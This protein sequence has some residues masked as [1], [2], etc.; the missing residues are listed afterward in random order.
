[1]SLI[2]SKKVSQSN[3]FVESPYAVELTTHE[4]K[5]I[6]YSI[7]HCREED[8]ALIGKKQGK[9]YSFTASNLAKILN[10]SLSRIVADGDKLA[11][12]ITQ[13]RIIH[14]VI[15]E[16]NE[17]EE[18]LYLPIIISAR[19][20]HGIFEFELNYKILPFFINI[21][22]PFTEYQLNHLLSMR[23]AYAIKLYKLLYQYK[24]IGHRKF[25]LYDLKAQFGIKDKYPQYKDLRK[26]VVE[27]AV[28]Q[29]NDLTDLT[30]EFN[31]VKFGKKVEKLEFTFNLKRQMLTNKLSHSS[32]NESPTID[33][34]LDSNVV[35]LN[36]MQDLIS[37]I[38]S[39]ISSI[40]KQLIA[41]YFKDKGISYVQASIEYAK[42]NS[43]TNFDKYLSDTLNNGWAEVEVKKITNKK[44][45][46]SAK[47]LAIKQEQDKKQQEKEQ[48]NLNR[49]L[50][51]HEWNKLLDADKVHYVDYAKFIISKHNKKLSSFTTIEQSLPL[52]IYAVSNQKFYDRVLEGYVK[53]ILNL[54]LNINDLL[55]PN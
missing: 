33:G 3:E 10:T 12:S 24:N 16:K 14:K 49:S 51:E 42:K 23:S 40:T 39:E 9:E 28:L 5:I 19:Y 43:K 46:D 13:K 6:E 35:T 30:V 34:S 48:D 41:R 15:N 45:K 7:A 54:S 21:N 32:T 27:P 52:C 29:I 26:R 11:N 38:D 25:T 37:G 50:I 8:Y 18:F 17:V 4:I 31:E 53:N 36:G 22:K 47:N 20:K 1:M 55:I 44:A 2:N